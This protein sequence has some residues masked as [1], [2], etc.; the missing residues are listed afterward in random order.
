MGLDYLEHYGTPRHSGRYPYGS[1]K[2]P[3]QSSSWLQQ[4]NKYHKEGKSETEIAAIM[5]M[6]T[7][8]LRERKSIENAKTRA[9]RTAEAIRLHNKG[10]SNGKIGEILGA[11]GKPIGES[12]IRNLLDPVLAERNMATTNIANALKDAVANKKYIDVAAGAEIY[13][14]CSKQRLKTAVRMLKDEGYKLYYDKV[15]QLGTSHETTIKALCAPDVPWK[16]MHEN[17]HL[18]GMVTNHKTFDD[19]RT[20][21]NIKD[22]ASVDPNRVQVRYAEE[23]GLQR[24]GV[25]QLRR[26]VADLSLGDAQYAQVRIKVGDSHYLKGMA[27]Y[28]DDLPDGVDI[29]FNTN[30]HKGTPMMG[31]KDNSVL[32]PIK[33]DPDNPFGA[34][35][36]QKNYIDADGNEKLSPI[37]IVGS[38]KTPNSEGSWSTWRDTLSSQILS[39]QPAPLVKQQLDK[40]YD[41]RAAEFDEI[42]K[43]TNPTVKKYLLEKFANQCESDAV[44]LQAAGMPRQQWHVILP[45]PDMSENEIYAPNYKNGE[46]VVL[47]RYPHAGQFEIPELTV[48]N[49]HPTADRL[50]HNARDAVGINAKV[51]EKLSGADFDGDTVLVIPNNDRAIKTAPSLPG[52]KNF[53]PKEEYAAYEGMKRVGP[54]SD[55][56]DK[57]FEMG[58]VSNLITDMTIMSAPPEDIERAVKHSMVVIDAEK[59]NLDWKRSY[60]ENGIADLKTKYQGGP[61]KG[62]ATIISRASSEQRIPQIKENTGINKYNELQTSRVEHISSEPVMQKGR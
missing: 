55:G 59:H 35:V 36:C 7:S 26:G 17:R 30:K 16:E 34:T 1:G 27:M 33:D 56:F 46:K 23:G 8:E 61:N 54:K 28:A 52:L 24:D 25:I 20:I 37:N 19:G 53:D 9:A 38:L 3:Y 5:G 45:F 11:P 13:L 32:K 12:T 43:L 14:G 50:I 48:N 42:N 10:Y 58:S 15:A 47:I 21:L 18:I 29:M 44:D 49:K 6:K 57:G 40:A 41:K 2:N 39:K 51:A 60:E 22:P 4:V 62:A 31:E